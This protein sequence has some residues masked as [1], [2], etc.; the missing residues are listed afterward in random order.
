M[1]SFSKL[2]YINRNINF[3]KRVYFSHICLQLYNSPNY[4][5]LCTEENYFVKIHKYEK[6]MRQ[7]IFFL[8]IVNI[9]G[10]KDCFRNKVTETISAFIKRAYFKVTCLF[11]NKM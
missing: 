5:V 3:K 2:F 9:L 4:N 1:E 10:S 11:D 6:I 7:L 8:I